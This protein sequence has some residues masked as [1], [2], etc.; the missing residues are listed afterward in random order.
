FRASRTRGHDRRTRDRARPAR[1]RQGRHAGLSELQPKGVLGGRHAARPVAGGVGDPRGP[2]SGAC[3]RQVL[4]GI[5]DAAALTGAAGGRPLAAAVTANVFYRKK[6]WK[7]NGERCAFQGLG[8]G[9]GRRAGFCSEVGLASLESEVRCPAAG[10]AGFASGASGA[11]AA[12]G[13][14]ADG[15]TLSALPRGQLKSSARPPGAA[16]GSPLGSPRGTVA[17]TAGAARPPPTSSSGPLCMA[18]SGTTGPANGRCAG[19]PGLAF[20]ACGPG[21]T[22]TGSATGM[23]RLVMLRWISRST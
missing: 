10:F 6:F 23:P 18:V 21:S 14:A 7:K 5:G 8:R 11:G 2:P 13:S 4:D 12:A 16:T 3:R 15:W 19:P 22:G 17:S 20:G 1:Q 9:R